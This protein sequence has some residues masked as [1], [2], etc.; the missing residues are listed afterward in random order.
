MM[1]FRNNQLYGM[2]KN[3]SEQFVRGLYQILL[4]ASKDD[5]QKYISTFNE[6]VKRQNETHFLKVNSILLFKHLLDIEENIYHNFC[7]ISENIIRNTYVLACS[8]EVPDIIFKYS[9]NKIETIISYGFDFQAEDCQMSLTIFR[10]EQDLQP[11]EEFDLMKALL[12]QYYQTDIIS[13]NHTICLSSTNVQ[14]IKFVN[15]LPMRYNYTELIIF[16]FSIFN[17]IMCQNFIRVHNQIDNY[18][19]HR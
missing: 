15:T 11:N 3:I 4:M 17:Q 1:S 13:L 19:E 5:Y 6:N 14:I 10:N 8:I 2:P 18:L 7:L 12:I 9:K 16:M